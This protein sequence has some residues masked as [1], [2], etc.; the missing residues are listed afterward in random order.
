MK[1]THLQILESCSSYLVSWK[2][3]NASATYMEDEFDVI[4]REI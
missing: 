2:Q 1:Q 4:I 3:G